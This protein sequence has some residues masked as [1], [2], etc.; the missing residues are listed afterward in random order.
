MQSQNALLSSGD[1]VKQTE[2]NSCDSRQK[3]NPTSAQEEESKKAE[4]KPE[5][6]QNKELIVSDRDSHAADDESS[7][8]GFETSSPDVRRGN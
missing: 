3:S 7:N 4:A 1:V 2:T 8:E 6:A 5:P